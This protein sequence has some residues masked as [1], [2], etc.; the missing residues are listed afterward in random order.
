MVTNNVSETKD[1]TMKE[2][3]VKVGGMTCQHCKMNV[4]RT[5]KSV[6]GIQVAEVDLTS[7]KVLLKGEEINLQAVRDGV[8]SIGYTYEGVL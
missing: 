7:G 5:L 4:E 1:E 8:E 3:L 6:P 2:L